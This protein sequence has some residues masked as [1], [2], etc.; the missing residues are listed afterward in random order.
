MTE[1]IKQLEI[2]VQKATE[3]LQK[4]RQLV[5]NKQVSLQENFKEE[6]R[7]F[8]VSTLN[9]GLHQIKIE[10]RTLNSV[11]VHYVDGEYER[12]LMEIHLY[13]WSK[14]EIGYIKLHCGGYQTLDFLDDDFE[15]E[16][17]MVSITRI[18]KMVEISEK[19]IPQ[20]E[21]IWKLAEDLSRD[22]YE[23]REKYDEIQAEEHSQKR[24]LENAEFD[25]K[26]SVI[27]EEGEI[28]VGED[29]YDRQLYIFGRYIYANKVAIVK[30]GEKTITIGLYSMGANKTPFMHNQKR[31]PKGKAE[32]LLVNFYDNSRV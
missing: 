26:L 30:E 22:L 25:H 3:R 23:I 12:L 5:Y 6:L 28:V 2:E 11:T 31:L 9:V 10:T 14:G 21:N 1:E 20:Y 29:G 8:M 4:E 27:R 15:M 24:R 16:T 19:I 17:A 32:R 7:A 13:M 18:R